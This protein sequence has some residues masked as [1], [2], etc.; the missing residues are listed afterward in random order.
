MKIVVWKS[1]RLLRGVL[2]MLFGLRQVFPVQTNKTF[3][4]C[5]RSLPF[6][7]QASRIELSSPPF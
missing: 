7:F 4:F 1:P 5:K 2:R 3:T 6:G